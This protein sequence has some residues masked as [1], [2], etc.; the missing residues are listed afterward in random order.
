MNVLHSFWHCFSVAYAS[1][2]CTSAFPKI[3]NVMAGMIW[4][5][6]AMRNILLHAAIVDCNKDSKGNQHSLEM[7]LLFTV[8]LTLP[9]VMTPVK[10]GAKKPGRLAAVF[11]T[12]MR[13][14]E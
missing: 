10:R 3:I 1:Y 7:I 14:P 12:D 6:A 4:K 13:K 9:W 8:N 5:L 11:V 2:F